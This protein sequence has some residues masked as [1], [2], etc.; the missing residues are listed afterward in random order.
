MNVERPAGHQSAGRSEGL[1]GHQPDG[2]G[3]VWR[4]EQPAPTC[5]CDLPVQQPWRTR[6]ASY[7][8]ATFIGGLLWYAVAVSALLCGYTTFGWILAGVLSAMLIG[9]LVLQA[10]RRHRGFCW[11]RRALWFGVAT[12]GLP[13]R[14]VAAFSF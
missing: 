1:T 14:L 12:P 3:G 8:P 9:S 13:V 7:S 4:A 2:P 11:L 5:P 6:D 10:I